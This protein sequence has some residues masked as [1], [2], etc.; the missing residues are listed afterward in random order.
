MR[1]DPGV[2]LNDKARQYSSLCHISWGSKCLPPRVPGL[3]L[4]LHHHE[5]GSYFSSYDFIFLKSFSNCTQ[6]I[7]LERLDGERQGHF[8]MKFRKMD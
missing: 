6:T 8:L 1:K 4:L 5:S 2:A 3:L 7:Y